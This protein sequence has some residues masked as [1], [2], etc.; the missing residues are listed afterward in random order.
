MM[1]GQLVGEGAHFLKAGALGTLDMPVSGHVL[2]PALVMDFEPPQ[3]D[4]GPYMECIT[5][6]G[7]EP[8]EARDQGG[9]VVTDIP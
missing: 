5:N 9:Q 3:D 6:S 2:H 1:F 4:A 8:L 7:M